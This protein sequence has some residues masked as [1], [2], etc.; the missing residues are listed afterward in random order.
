MPRRSLWVCNKCPAPTP[1]REGL[2]G[3]WKTMKSTQNWI[4]HGFMVVYSSSTN[5]D[6]ATISKCVDQL[7]SSGTM[8]WK[9]REHQ[10][11]SQSCEGMIG[12]PRTIKKTRKHTNLILRHLWERISVLGKAKSYLQ[13]DNDSSPPFIPNP[14]V[15]VLVKL[16]KIMLK[17]LAL[18]CSQ[19]HYT[20]EGFLN[21]PFLWIFHE[22]NRPAI[23][24]P[25]FQKKT[26]I[27]P[28][29]I[30]LFNI[31]MENHHF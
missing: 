10:L 19:P 29:I 18:G 21:H 17:D 15:P 11:I 28:G 27:P 25:P 2:D 8:N 3:D 24:V 30:W 6:V 14:I 9:S 13:R 5:H 26:H 12:S 23:G 7:N 16:D 22:I 1:R 4:L 20:Y 31:A